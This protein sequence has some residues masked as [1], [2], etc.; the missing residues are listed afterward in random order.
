[1]DCVNFNSELLHLSQAL[2]HSGVVT[3][4]APFHVIHL[5]EGETGHRFVFRLDKIRGYRGEPLNEIGLAPGRPVRF[6]VDG[7]R[8]TAVELV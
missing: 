3:R 8:V 5:D 6:A 1:M 2:A 7:E 4:I